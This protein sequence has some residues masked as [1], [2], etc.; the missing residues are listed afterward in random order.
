MLIES[1]QKLAARPSIDSPAK[2]GTSLPEGLAFVFDKYDQHRPLPTLKGAIHLSDIGTLSCTPDLSLTFLDR[3][4]AAYPNQSKPNIL[5]LLNIPRPNSLFSNHS[6]ST[7]EISLQ[8]LAD[9]LQEQFNSEAVECAN[10]LKKR[11]RKMRGHKHKKRLKER[12]HK[13]DK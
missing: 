5:T 2:L 8:S 11:R 3:L 10:V 6:I 1:V 4:V 12:R 7:A 9:S 13:A